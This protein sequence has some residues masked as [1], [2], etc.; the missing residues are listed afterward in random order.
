MGFL[1]EEW[2]LRTT[3][4][5]CS[6]VGGAILSLQMIMMLIG[7]DGDADFDADGD[8]DSGDSDGM[9][10]IS[11]RG[12]ASFLTF[13]GLVGWYGLE[14]GWSSGKSTLVGM[15]AGSAMMLLVAFIM[16]QYRKL[17]SEGNL[18]P[19]NAVGATA[20]VYLKIPGNGSGR[21]KITVAIQERTHEY[22]ATTKGPEIPTGAEVR[23]VRMITENT[24]EVE[25][26]T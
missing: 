21:G 13:F 2:T 5:L 20:T 6:A 25:V 23:V 10:L 12:I 7:F 18:K 15:A 9:G 3:Y 11:I 22:Q 8:F 1:P 4:M 14:N 26:I 19:E 16:T 24:F 17:A